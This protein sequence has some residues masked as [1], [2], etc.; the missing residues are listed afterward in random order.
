ML[1]I[2]KSLKEYVGIINR[3]KFIVFEDFQVENKEELINKK[4]PYIKGDFKI[5]SGNEYQ[6]HG[7]GCLFVSNDK[8]WHIDW[9][10]GGLKNQWCGINPRLFNF[11]LGTVYQHEMDPEIHMRIEQKLKKLVED[12]L[13]AFHDGLYYFIEDLTTEDIDYLKKIKNSSKHRK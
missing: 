4:I 5:K 1:E 13:M 12:E 7:R 8:A 6:F 10:F 2:I 3:L 11:Y 9:D